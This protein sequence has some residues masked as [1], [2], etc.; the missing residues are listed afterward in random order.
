MIV[1]ELAR[2]SVEVRVAH[3]KDFCYT[4]VWI[5]KEEKR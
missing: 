4:G 3:G 2:K 1:T 5:W